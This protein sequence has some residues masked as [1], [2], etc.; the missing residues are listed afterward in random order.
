VSDHP[1]IPLTE[2]LNSL[3]AELSEAQ[4]AGVGN[5][6]RLQVEKLEL[7]VEVASARD[8]GAKT[9]VKFW[10]VEAGVDGRTKWGRTQRLKLTLAPRLADGSVLEVSDEVTGR[11]E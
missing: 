2:W 9:G 8:L 4:Q 5:E 11:P 7:E 10:V 1:P 6:L 3:R